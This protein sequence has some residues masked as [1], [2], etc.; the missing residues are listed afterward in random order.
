MF[1]H[2][3]N[4]FHWSKETVTSPWK[5]FDVTGLSGVIAQRNADLLNAEVDSLLEINEGPRTPNM[6]FDFFA[7]DDLARAGRQ[8]SENLQGLLLEVYHNTG[9]T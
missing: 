8:Q 5:G 9:F 3:D 1:T 6:P 4:L 2:L 7:R